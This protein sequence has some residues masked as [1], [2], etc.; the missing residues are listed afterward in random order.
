MR[1][2]RPVLVIGGAMCVLF[3][4]FGASV[5]FVAAL[6]RAAHVKPYWVWTGR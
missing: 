1:W 5:L 3:P 4:I 2:P 6:G